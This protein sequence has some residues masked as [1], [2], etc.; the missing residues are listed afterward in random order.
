V[1][2]VA[3]VVVPFKGP[4]RRGGGRPDS[5]D[6]GGALSKWWPVM[7]GGVRGMAPSDEGK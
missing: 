1:K 4:E 5:D 2:M 6:R 3:V 7:E